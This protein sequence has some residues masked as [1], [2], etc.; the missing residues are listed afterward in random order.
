MCLL[1][2]LSNKLDLNQETRFTI[3][4]PTVIL[5]SAIMFSGIILSVILLGLWRPLTSD[6]ASSESVAEKKRNNDR[7]TETGYDLATSQ[8]PSNCATTLAIMTLS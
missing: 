8:K 1:L 2:I 3:I 7:M 6:G 5:I 4:L